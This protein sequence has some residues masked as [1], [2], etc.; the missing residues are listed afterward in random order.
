MYLVVDIERLSSVCVL[1][2][3]SV[4]TSMQLHVEIN[5]MPH[6]LWGYLQARLELARRC[7]VA[8]AVARH[9]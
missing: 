7:R 6:A 5:E 3:D 1:V 8:A 2:L 4:N 9:A